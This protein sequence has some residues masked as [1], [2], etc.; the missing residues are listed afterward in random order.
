MELGA[1]LIWEAT[2]GLLL[3]SLVIC[4]VMLVRRFTERDW[5]FLFGHPPREVI[6]A[7]NW[8]RF[9]VPFLVV[10]IVGLGIPFFVFSYDCEADRSQHPG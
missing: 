4:L 8:I 9:G 6:A 5:L 7:R 2:N 1:Y 10:V 3:L